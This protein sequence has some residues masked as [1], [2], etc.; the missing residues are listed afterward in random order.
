MGSAKQYFFRLNSGGCS[1][2]QDLYRVKDRM[3]ATLRN[4]RILYRAAE[5]RLDSAA[6]QNLEEGL[7][8]T[9]AAHKLVCYAGNAHLAN[10]RSQKYGVRLA[11]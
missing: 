3:E 11:A 4:A 7:K 10:Q 8:Q 6:V 9:S 1:T 2:C 5:N